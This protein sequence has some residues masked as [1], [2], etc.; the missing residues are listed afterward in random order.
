M[1]LI[2]GERRSDKAKRMG[3]RWEDEALAAIP[4]FEA[5]RACGVDPAACKFVNWF[6]DDG[7]QVAREYAG[8]IIALG[9][10]VQAAM[11]AEGLDHI[12]LVHPAARGAIRL[13]KNYIAHVREQLVDSSQSMDLGYMD[14]KRWR[15]E[16]NIY[17]PGVID[18]P[19]QVKRDLQHRDDDLEICPRC[20]I[21]IR[22][23]GGHYCGSCGRNV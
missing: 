5:L 18:H 19:R 11:R 7:A 10:K 2:V 22:P 13:R 1:Y 14:P 21:L 4:L 23:E 9:N 6:E 3:V 16:E 20:D 17:S 12:P 8:P 15:S